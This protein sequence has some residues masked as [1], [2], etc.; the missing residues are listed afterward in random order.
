MDHVFEELAFLAP[1]WMGRDT[2]T[3]AASDNPGVIAIA[4][5]HRP[6]KAAR[7]HTYVVA[8]NQSYEPAK[9][10]LTVPILARNKSAR[11]L[12]LREN[13]V[14]PVA[15]GRFTDEF[16]GLGAHVYTTLEV[17]PYFETL[18]AIEKQIA[19]ALERPR[20]EGNLLASGKVRWAIGAFGRRFASDADLA[21]GARNAAGWFPVY[22]DRTQCLVVF[23]KPVTFSRVDLYSPTI[24]AAD[25]DAWI[26][27]KWKTLH[28]WKDEYLYRLAYQGEKVTTDKVRIRPTAARQGYGSWLIHEITELGIYE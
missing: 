4:K 10:T 7:G 20:R 26:D 19:T 11:L 13:R 17:V 18:E 1:A 3:D 23:E 8:A 15:D 6:P 22:D 5:F 16:A 2:A 24:R 14:I 12:V 28:Q 9:A 25:L 21:D 27:G